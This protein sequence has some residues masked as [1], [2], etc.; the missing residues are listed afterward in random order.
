MLEE[1]KK[2]ESILYVEDEE[3]IREE[4]S[5]I[6]ETFCDTLYVAEKWSSWTGT[7]Y[8]AYSKNYYYRY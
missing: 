7:L 3:G 6:L 4:L 2:V 5:D 8:K 1:F